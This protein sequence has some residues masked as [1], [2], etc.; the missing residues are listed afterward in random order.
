M[1]TS[2]KT[3]AA[4]AFSDNSPLTIVELDLQPPAAGQVLVQLKATG[5]CHTD[6]QFIDGSRNYSDYPIVLGHEGA[7][8]VV[9]CGAGVSSVVPGDH[10]IPLSIPQCGICKNCL[11]GKTNICQ[12]FIDTPEGVVKFSYEGESVN[13]FAGLGTFSEYTV[14]PEYALAQVSSKAP[15][16]I[17]C[18]LGCAVATGVGA[19]LY[20]ADIDVGN[21]VAVFGIG[22]IGVNVIQGA[23]LAGAEKIIAIDTNPA[24]KDIALAFGAT[25]FIN[26]SAEADGLL[27][28]VR[29]LSDGGVDVSFEC[30]GSPRL[31]NTAIEASHIGWGQ[32]VLIGIPS[33]GQQLTIDPYSLF[34]GR[35]LMSSWAGNT[36]MRSQL[37][38]IVEW[39]LQGRIELDA[40]VS[41]RFSLEQINSGFDLMKTGEALRSVVVY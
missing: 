7:G 20:T 34:N 30:V 13:A 41:H 4:V 35:K 29:V 23:K 39:Y 17:M 2:I 10:V 19:A 3:R 16:E 6:L 25:D 32:T 8:V 31:I 1:A 18:C 36:R 11:S 38:E 28:A 9:E 24:K 15:L 27:E 33:G 22:G 21:S 14:V 26:A 12:R 40:L 37:P 5:L